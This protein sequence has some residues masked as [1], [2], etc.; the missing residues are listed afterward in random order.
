MIENTSSY[1]ST[2]LHKANI[3]FTEDGIKAAAVTLMGGLGAGSPFDYYFDVPVEE[4]DMTFDNP[5]MFLI[6]DKETGETWFAGTVYEPLSWEDE[7][8]NNYNY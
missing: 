7:P 1:I 8:S 6:R 2:A 5:Y 3:E 4:I